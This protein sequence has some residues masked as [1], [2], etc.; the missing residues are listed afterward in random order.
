MTM[1][2]SLLFLSTGLFVSTTLAGQVPVVDGVIGG[3]PTSFSTY[4]ETSRKFFT[5]ST[6]AA[7]TPGKLRVKENTGICE[8]TP[9][10]YQAS[11]YG[12]ITANKSMWFWFFAARNNA[13][14]AP[15][16]L[17]F[18]GGPGSSSM[19]GLFQEHGPC[20]INNDTKTVSLNPFSWNNEVNMLYI[21]QPIGTGFSYG[22]LV[23]VGTSQAAAADVWSFLQIFFND[24][25]FAPYLPNK[26]ALWTESYGGHYGPTFA[27]HILNQNSAIDAGTVSGVKLNLQVLGIGNGLTD[28]LLQYPAYLTYAAN[29]AYH[30]L[31][32]ANILDA[33]TQAWNSTDGCQSLISACYN[34][35]SNTTCTNAQF[36]C[37][38]NILGPLAGQWDVYYVPTANPDPYP[39]NI[40]DYLASIG[41]AAGADVAWQ[42]TSPDVYDDFS[43]SGDWMRN[44]R[45]DLETVINSGVRTLIYD[46]DADFIVNYMGVEAMVDALDTQFSALYKQQSWSTYNVQGQPAGQYKNAGTFS[47][48]RVF[49][50]GHEVPA[51]KFGTLQYGQVA[52]QMFTQIMRNES[53]SPTEDAEELFEKRAAI[54]S[55]R[56]VLATRDMM[57]W[58]YNVASF[59]YDDNWRIH[60]R[61]SQ[62]HLKAESAHMYHPIQ[63]RKVHDMMAGLLDSPERLEEHNKMLSISIPLTTMYGYEVKS[64]DDPVI[65]AADRSVELGLKVVALGGSLVNILPIFKY[66][67]WTWTQRVTKEVKRLTEDMKR[68]PLEALL[69]DMAAGTAIPSLVGNFMERKQTAGATAEEEER[70]ILNVA[71][72]VYSAAADTTISAT[73]TFFYLLTTHQDVQRK[74]QAEIDRVLGSPRLPTFEDRASLPYIEAIYRETLRWYPPVVMGLPHVSTED[75]WYKGYFIPKGTALFANIWA[76][77]RDEEKYGPDS[78]AFNPDRFFDKDGKLNDDDRILAYG[79][80]RRNCVGKYVASSTLWLMMVTT[81]ACFYLRKQKD[82]K[83]NEIEIDDEFDE[84]GL[85]GHKKEFQCDIT[86]RSK[87]WRDVI[88]AARTQGYKF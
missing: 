8:T 4:H 50:A 14:T 47:Y 65:V 70:R 34:G 75:D 82:E 38:N 48:I 62:Q 33:A 35:G 56:I 74:A 66:V 24:T 13:S 41:A 80:G 53:L 87:E 16:A 81:L 36:F 51:Y 11:G 43:F 21:D 54:Y 84:H 28:A 37:N 39:P 60:R 20:R 67:P 57:G 32:P 78:Y 15:V 6:A 55:S 63:S 10:V 79:F 64:L 3:V 44:S 61:I 83:G 29:N 31:V 23:D 73:K 72:T 18:N 77:N 71:N 86:P 46:G 85:V 26:L 17:W 27:A 9:G 52:A 19:I 88:E 42:M 59:T 49:G 25:R 68:I 40:T 45:P 2:L 12:D 5:V 30:P 58:D 1:R 69:R 76:I 7:T 22:D